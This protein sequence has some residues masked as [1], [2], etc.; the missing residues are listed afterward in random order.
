VSALF[1]MACLAGGGVASGAFGPLS[2]WLADEATGIGER[3]VVALA[4]GSSITLDSATS[5]D[6]KYA[7]NERRIVL[8]DGQIFVTVAPDT[9]RPFIVEARQGTVRALGTAFNVRAYDGGARVAVTEHAV[10]VAYGV[11]DGVD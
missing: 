8:R 11:T 4:D 9:A 6:V 7:A 3:R 5:V 10:R 1:V 2:G